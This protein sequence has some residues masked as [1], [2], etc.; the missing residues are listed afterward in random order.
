MPA[1]LALSIRR[2]I[3]DR[4]QSGES[5]AGI[6]RALQLGYT[7]VRRVWRQFQ[8]EGQVLPHYER[9]RQT[10]IRKGAALYERAVQLKQAHPGWGAGLIRLELAAADAAY[11]LP[12]E[13]TLQRWFRRAGVAARSVDRRAHPPVQRGKQAHDVWAIDAKEQIRLADGSYCSWLT[14]TDEGSGAILAAEL[15]PHT[16]VEPGRPTGGQASAPGNPAP[17]GLSRATADG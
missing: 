7:T 2:E 5:L 1:A 6:A 13:R 15:F 10:S 3:V 16:P 11:S 12:S 14:I 8:T 9:C 4:R 17:V